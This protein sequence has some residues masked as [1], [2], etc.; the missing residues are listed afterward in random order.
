MQ[1]IITDIENNPKIKT[2][3]NKIAAANIALAHELDNYYMGKW[4][5]QSVAGQMARCY[6]SP[7]VDREITA[8]AWKHFNIKRSAYMQVIRM[9]EGS[10]M[11]TKK[12]L[13]NKDPTKKYCPICKNKIATNAHVLLNCPISKKSQIRKHDEIAEIIYHK[14]ES[15][16]TMSGVHPI[17]H[18]RDECGRTLMWNKEV[19]ARSYGPFAKRPDIFY[20]DGDHA[21]IIDVTIV[22][23][24]NIRK[25]YFKKVN[26]YKQLQETVRKYLKV[27]DV[28]IIPIVLT[29]NGLIN[30]YSL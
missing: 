11:N 24:Q 22:S 16:L 12:A 5:E 9:Q 19:V 3:K 10:T 30:D 28:Q 14:I 20:I 13:F 7:Y 6:D 27:K 21:A 8:R 26:K 18:Y 4:K 15:K 23:D 2:T 17:P 29:I 25:A 1:K